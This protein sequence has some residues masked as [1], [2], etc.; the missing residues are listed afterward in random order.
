MKIC[1]SSYEVNGS[2]DTKFA[3]LLTHVFREYYLYSKIK[4]ILAN[5]YRSK[6]S[7]DIVILC[8]M[9]VADLARSFSKCC[10]NI[11]ET[12]E[13]ER[14]QVNLIHFGLDYNNYVRVPKIF[15]RKVRHL[16]V[17]V[18]KDYVYT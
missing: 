11:C 15:A 16:R 7:L 13:N 2:A 8:G 14:F 10:L 4:I 12:T 1:V 3:L 18:V 17:R 5:S 6:K 9:K